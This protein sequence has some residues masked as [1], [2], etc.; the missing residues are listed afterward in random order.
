MSAARIAA[1]RP[2][3]RPYVP[4]MSVGRALLAAATRAASPRRWLAS[5]LA[6]LKVNPPRLDW[7]GIDRKL[8]WHELGLLADRVRPTMPRNGTDPFYALG[9]IV[10]SEREYA[11][12][13]E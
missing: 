5:R 6:E 9:P 4:R 7:G 8:P 2:M 1:D 3:R 13:A 12:R 10:E 11:T